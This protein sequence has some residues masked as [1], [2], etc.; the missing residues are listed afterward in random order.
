MVGPEQ[1]IAQEPEGGARP[2]E[3]PGELRRDCEPHR[4]RLILALAGLAEFCGVFAC[5]LLG[6]AP[7]SIALSVTTW[8]GC[9]RGS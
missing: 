1:D 9:G 4:A 2:W 7:L 8:P 6:T 3:R 5:L